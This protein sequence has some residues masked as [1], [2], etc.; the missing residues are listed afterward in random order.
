MPT[1]RVPSDHDQGWCAHECFVV[2]G[3]KVSH[4]DKNLVGNIV[5]ATTQ[6]VYCREMKCEAYSKQRVVLVTA[7][8]KYDRYAI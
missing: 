1:G 2:N 7:D 4:T 6:T 3:S 5:T 8:K